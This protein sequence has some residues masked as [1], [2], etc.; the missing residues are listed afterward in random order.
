MVEVQFFL[1]VSQFE[2]LFPWIATE[3]FT[4]RRVSPYAFHVVQHGELSAYFTHRAGVAEVFCLFPS[5]QR[6]FF[7]TLAFHFIGKEKVSRNSFA[8]GD[9]LPIELLGHKPTVSEPLCLWQACELLFFQFPFF[10]EL[11]NFAGQERVAWVTCSIS[12]TA[13]RE[14]HRLSKKKPYQQPTK[15]LFADQS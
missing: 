5:E 7:K 3:S 1:I 8:R 15:L 14:G 10:P 11:S 6:V 12:G 13:T 2:P 9:T 4:I